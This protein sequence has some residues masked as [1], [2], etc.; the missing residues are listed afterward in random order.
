MKRVSL[1][2]V[3]VMAILSVN[4]QTFPDGGFEN[5]WKQYTCEKGT[6]WDFVEGHFIETLNQLYDLPAENGIAPLTAFREDDA[7]D[8]NYALKLV[9]D[10]MIFGNERIFLPGAC[11]SLHI[12]FFDI[13][14]ILGNPFTYRPTAMIGYMK[15]AP[16]NGD[17]AAIEVVLKKNSV[18]IGSGKIMFYNAVNA[19]TKFTVDINYTSEATPDSVIVIVASSANYDF[20]SIETLMKC[21][22]QVGSTI[23]ID[24]LAF[25]YG[26]GVK[27]LILSNTHVNV[28]PNPACEQLN[29]QLE[30]DVDGEVI[31]YDNNGKQML[32]RQVNGKQFSI[33]INTLATGHYFLNIVNN[34]QK[35]IASKQFVKE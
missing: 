9:S 24:E 23:Y 16:V 1:F 2:L 27:E 30:Q 19:Y 7:Y 13:D 8:G 26:D 31:V 35:I 20:T 18:A 28:Y 22:G 29:I 25:E 5:C 34:D 6:Y 33:D 11:G 17:S 4:A 21:K 15:Y 14:C 10:T 3:A 12:D 32:N